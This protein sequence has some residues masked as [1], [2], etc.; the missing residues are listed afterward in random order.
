VKKDKEKNDLELSS[1]NLMEATNYKVSKSNALIEASYKLTIDEQRIILLLASLVE[2]HDKEFKIYKFK[3]NDLIK[4]LG[5]KNKNKYRQIREH[6]MALRQKGFTIKEGN[7]TLDIGWLSSS[8]YYD[9]EGIVELCFDPKL[10]P[11]LLDLKTHYTTYPMRSAFFLRSIYSVRI[12]EL[13]KQYQ[14][15]GKRVFELMELRSLL[16]ID[17]N[18]YKLYTD[19]KRTVI[20]RSQQ[21]LEEKTELY[22]EF[23]EQKTGKKVTHLHFEI[24]SS[25][26]NKVQEISKEIESII[27]SSKQIA[28]TSESSCLFNK[29][30]GFG[31]H[32]S[33]AKDLIDKYEDNYI[34]ENILQV[35][36]DY[37]S[38][39]VKDLAGYVVAA[40]KNDYRKQPVLFEEMKKKEQE[41]RKE[42]YKNI[43]MT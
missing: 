33:S 19:F 3:V 42:K 13:L 39:K 38:G 29:L 7:K 4:L 40:I 26:N 31:V 8:V 6:A 24:I 41:K 9:G 30:I 15:I 22:F 21:E 2:P 23:E 36:E 1:N 12:Y 35:E 18:E 34:L 14:K 28:A 43:Y 20:I 10:K 16:G 32:P 27:E 5:I 37:K 11:F 17:D 25:A